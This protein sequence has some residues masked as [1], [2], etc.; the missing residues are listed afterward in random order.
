MFKLHSTTSY[1]SRLK[2]NGW[3]HL[4][5]YIN[6]ERPILIYAIFKFIFLS[7]FSSRYYLRLSHMKSATSY[8]SRRSGLSRCKMSVASKFTQTPNITWST[9]Q[10]LKWE[11]SLIP[12]TPLSASRREEFFGLQLFQA[13]LIVLGD[14]YLLEIMYNIVGQQNS[15]AKDFVFKKAYT[16]CLRRGTPCGKLFRR[17]I[18]LFF[19][20]Q[21]LH[22]ETKLQNF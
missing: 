11:P 20:S 8:F 22:R 4:L 17:I 12:P 13:S 21:Y 19:Y 10:F 16:T 5:T 15:Q 3:L 9:P 6:G 18:K 2:D 7:L 14:N 1:I